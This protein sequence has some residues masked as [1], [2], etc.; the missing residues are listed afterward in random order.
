MLGSSL[1]SSR[2]SPSIDAPPLRWGVMGTGWIAERFVTALRQ[3]TRQVSHAV[4]SRSAA[5]AATFAADHGLPVA[6]GSYDDLVGDPSV[7]VVYVAT[8]HNHHLDAALAAIAA[9]KHVV[10][11]KPLGVNADEA[12][13]IASA[14]RR[15][16]VYCVEAM[17]TLF[18]PKFDVLR[19]LVDDGAVGQPLSVVAD[20]GEWFDDSHRIRRA[21]LAGGAMLD[22]GTYPVSLATW[23]LG[24]PADVVALATRAGDVTAQFGT[25]LRSPTGAIA[26]L[27]SSIDSATPTTATIAGTEG[28]IVL[29]GPFYMPGRFTVRD[30]RGTQ[31]VWDE[32][33]VGHEGLHF[34]AAAFAWDIAHGREESPI[35]PLQASIETLRTMDRITAAG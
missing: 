15:R 6:H 24:E 23:V 18:L 16:G 20:L 12:E 21:D 28:E 31:L 26:T 14:A 1:P 5:S 11:E 29:D 3:H 32:P 35:R 9:G 33:A 10:V 19:Q 27:Y 2:V 34:E 8:P 17:W 25:V 7:D 22:L 4:G 13:R 30:R